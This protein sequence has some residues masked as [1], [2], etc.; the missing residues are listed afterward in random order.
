M[1]PPNSSLKQWNS[2]LINSLPR[3][4]WSISN[5]L[6][7][8]FNQIFKEEGILILCNIFQ[9][10]QEGNTSLFI[11]HGQHY[12]NQRQSHIHQKENYVCFFYKQKH[13][14]SANN[15]QSKF[16]N[17]WQS[18]EFYPV[19]SQLAQHWG[20]NESKDVSWHRV[21]T[22]NMCKALGSMSSITN[23]KRNQSQLWP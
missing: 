13:K 22:N 23:I 6:N 10:T 18:H 12:A 16:K 19:N 7:G 14:C 9:K 21:L 5:C 3:K 11:L 4:R 1:D 15:Q 2:K 8:K 20:K 17:T